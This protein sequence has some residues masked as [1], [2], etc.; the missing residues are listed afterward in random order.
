LLVASLALIATYALFYEYLP[1]FKRVHLWSDV[2]GYHYPL[3]RYAFQSLKAG[4]I[5]QWDPSIYCGISF[6][7]NVQAAFLYPPTWLMYAA[8]WNLPRIPFKAMEVFTF[9][10]VWMAFL[11]CYM[12][13][14]GRGGKLASAL[15]AGVFAWTGYMMYQ[16]LHP[17]VIG[18]MTW[19]P[20]ALWGVD[21]AVDRRDWRP[22]WKVAAASALS[23]LAGY[24]AS[25]MVNCVIIAVYALGSRGHWRA[26][27]GACVALAASVLL[28]MAQLLPAMDARSFMVLEQKYG[29]GAYGW[30]TLLR[31]YFVPN[32]FDFNPVHHT[33]FD[34]GCI[35]LYL[36]LP[37]LFAIVWAIW[38]HRGRAYLQPV[39]GLAVALLFA[40][41][42]DF[43]LHTVERIPALKYT[44]QP[45][46]FYAAVAA[47][48]AL[49]TAIGLNDFLENR[50]KFPIPAWALFASG[51]ALVGWSFRDLLIWRRGGIFPTGT[52]AVAQ[53]A[54]ALALFSLG[55]W[56]VRQST[57]RRRIL[58]SGMLLFAA[59]SDYKVFGSGRWFNAVEGDVDDEHLPYGMRGLDDAGYRAMR[60]NRH[61][62]VFTDDGVGPHPT[63]YR[64]WGLSTPEGFDPFLSV[65]YKQTIQHWTPFFTNRLFYIDDR[66]DNML[67]TLGVRYAL[68]R[69]G[70]DHDRY[71]AASPDFRR[72]GR[73][74]IYCHVYEYLRA[75]PPFH[76]EDEAGGLAE[77]VAW[78]PERREFLTLSARGG[79]FVLV[80]QFFPGWRATVDGHPVRIERWGGAFQSIR[81]TPGTHRVSFEF[82]PVSVRGGAAVSFLAVAGLLVLVWADWRSR[83]F[84]STEQSP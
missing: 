74:D 71:L 80:E 83:R 8:V 62:R 66:N 22:L 30:G 5:P 33:D 17:G 29:P 68:V 9:L 6:A 53:T 36:G 55:L 64:M 47:M 72:I 7:G 40:N 13:L 46:N 56:C 73:T 67:Q 77:P 43:L 61:Y 76:W 84:V 57:G 14:R 34:P 78:L 44:M 31:S 58:I 81:V 11:L 10:H 49:I 39:L 70:S 69:D 25:W 41:P 32:W 26:A 28:F 79:R 20:L 82:R 15:G 42:P 16:V 1:P 52:G 60:A 59:A 12:W 27:I 35:Y 75:K 2:A 24:P 54:I 23:F 37:A 65:Q 48:A 45:H 18:A 3:Q 51:I 63:D 21:E 19:L 50:A 38:R 4:R